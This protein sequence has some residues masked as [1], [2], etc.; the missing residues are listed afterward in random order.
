MKALSAAASLAAAAAATVLSTGCGG[1][2]S[3]DLF[4]VQ[5]SGSTPGA[6]LT[7]LV[8]EEGVARCN[9]GKP[10]R[11]GD[12][13]IIQARTIQEDLHNYAT[14]DETLAPQPGSVLS[15]YVRD[16]DGSVRFADNSAGQPQVMRQLAAFVLTVAQQACGLPQTGA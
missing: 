13:Q 12:S 14:K 10:H 2:I 7:L 3:A 1:V 5:R 15:Y 8:S 11:L 16:A 9:G 6:R 4:L